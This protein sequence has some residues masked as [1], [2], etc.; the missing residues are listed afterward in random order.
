M[1]DERIAANWGREVAS[2]AFKAVDLARPYDSRQPDPSETLPHMGYMPL[3]P[4]S[5]KVRNYY[6]IAV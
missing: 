5:V 1:I 4:V 3:M 6:A 2:I